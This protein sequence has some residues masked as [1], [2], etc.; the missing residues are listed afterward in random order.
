[1][2]R[3][4]NGKPA[5]PGS[6]R[7]PRA[8][9]IRFSEPEEKRLLAFIEESYRGAQDDHE[10]RKRDFEQLYGLWRDKVGQGG[11]ADGKSN[12]RVPLV[13][14]VLL[15]KWA[16]V[17][18]A[19][20]GA[21][22]EIIAEPTGPV[23]QAT[24]HKVSRYMSWQ[25]FNHMEIVAPLAEF[26]FHLLVFGRA[27][28][29]CEWVVEKLYDASGK[30]SLWYEGPRFTP[31]L[32]DNLV[33]PPMEQ[34]NDPNDFPW[35][36]LRSWMTPD[37]LLRGE[38][39]GRF[40]NIEEN[41][42]DLVRASLEKRRYET[43]DDAIQ[44]Q[45]QQAEGVVTEYARTI[46]ESLEVRE[47]YMRWRMLKGDQDSELYDFQDREKRET[48]IVV[49][50]I[51]ATGTII[52]IRNLAEVYP[53]TPRRRPIV[54]ASILKDGSYWPAG[55]AERLSPTEF[56]MTMNHN[57]MQDAG[58]IAVSPPIFARPGMGLDP[59]RIQQI[60]P[61]KIY[62][63]D[64]PSSVKQ[65]E[66]NSRLEFAV[67]AGQNLLA[68]AERLEGISDQNLSRSLSQPNAPRTFRGQAL[69]LGQ[70][71]LRNTLEMLFM[72]DDWSKIL[73]HIKMLMDTFG[74]EQEEFRVT[75]EEASGQFETHHGF[76]T[77][78]AKERSGK[79]DFRFKF[80]TSSQSR[81]ARK[82]RM[83]AWLQVAAPMPIFVQNPNLQKEVL[84]VAARELQLE[85]L[86]PSLAALPDVNLPVNPQTEWA[87]A[88]QGIDPQVHPADND[89]E[90]LEDHKQRI[91]EHMT[92]P[93]DQ[94]DM[95]AAHRMIAHIFRH[96]EQ[97][98]RKMEVLAM[99]QAQAQVTGTLQAAGLLPEGQGGAV[100]NPE[101]LPGGGGFGDA[102][103]VVEPGLP[104]ANP[105]GTTPP[106][107]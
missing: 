29:K 100:G 16:R 71:D 13:T 97:V 7:L 34:A 56:E 31:L 79:Y 75:E 33:L 20:L 27:H 84:K 90:H 67:V 42:E 63:S 19:L 49:R 78:T 23:D 93:E 10:K 35:A 66:M 85:G 61:G 92:L 41:F 101:A 88:L 36:C 91:A 105:T 12:Y 59:Q 11:G 3:S 73:D 77:I 98:E 83:I 39:E 52:D 15:A 70:G 14:W 55:V 106:L 21:D 38:A 37:E 4:P 47:F 104:S 43:D 82:E 46:R 53:L 65:M 64:D 24:Q 22:K 99:A 107:T 50:Y 44:R 18:D 9:Q 81:E 8:K 86:L 48:E 54:T 102:T 6:R 103:G 87:Q 17:L 72:G 60:E 58:E 74:P 40:Y 5:P 69:L 80:A 32:P 2:S 51:P 95:D 68:V 25:V 62:W 28:A 89:D 45:R 57:L 26:T 96:E 30:G 76:A 94:R 1:M